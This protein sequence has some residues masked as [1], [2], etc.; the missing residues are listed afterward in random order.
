M[1]DATAVV[2]FALLGWVYRLRWDDDH[3]TYLE[4]APLNSDGQIDG[5]W[6]PLPKTPETDAV[7][8]GM[9]LTRKAV[10]KMSGTWVQ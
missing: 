1:T 4:M 5:D 9:E 3:R 8:E 2:A 10:G 7:I 6:T